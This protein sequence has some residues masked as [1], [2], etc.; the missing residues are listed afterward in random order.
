MQN[1]SELI[2]RIKH[3]I[4]QLSVTIGE[5]PTGS[6]ANHRAEHYIKQIFLD[7]QLQVKLQKFDCID[8]EKNK[9]TL[10]IGETEV[11]VEPSPYSLP[12]NVQADIAVVENIS[13]LEQ[14]DLAG[15]IAVLC[16]GLTQE[17][18]M[19]KNFSFY[20]PEHHQKIIHLLEEKKPAAILTASLNDKQLVPVFE[21]GDFD[22]SSA[23][24]STND[25][26]VIIQSTSPIHLSIDSRRKK[27]T[28]AN[29]IARRNQTTRNKFVV[30]AHFDTKP[31][32]LGALDNAVGVAVLLTLSELLKDTSL[33]N[34]GV[35]FVAFNGEDYFSMPGQTAY[36]NTYGSEFN[37]ITLAINC[38]GL[39]LKNSKTS[40][41][42]ME[43]SEKCVSQIESIRQSFR[44]IEQL[45]P[46]YQGDHMLFASAQ[47][48]TLAITSTGIFDLVDTVIHTTRDTQDLT[49]P[50]LIYEA[51]LFLQAV[52]N[53]LGQDASQG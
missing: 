8:W 14:I 2:K 5:R 9:T 37:Q 16:G 24:F 17:P 45:P 13:Q 12:C 18:L 32:T 53:S 23:V 35:E 52:M 46:W 28:G 40:I 42:F 30:T 26:D 31:G 51:C 38:D 36:L 22:I 25:K 4:Q 48:P 20:N 7:N 11:H 39:G 34:A 47:V 1:S 29:V 41:S 6:A 15:K 44:T 19:P 3:H 27:A 49:D 33:I 10:H 21:D 43:C 50:G